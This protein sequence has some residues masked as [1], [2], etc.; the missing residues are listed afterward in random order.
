MF[1][2]SGNKLIEHDKAENKAN[3]TS[4]GEKQTGL[5]SLDSGFI[6]NTQHNQA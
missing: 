6:N 3:K 5:D 2:D 1:G 4:L